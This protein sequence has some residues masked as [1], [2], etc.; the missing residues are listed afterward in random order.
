MKG[1]GLQFLILTWVG[2]FA[3]QN[4]SAQTVLLWGM[5]GSDAA[6]S[7]GVIFSIRGD[8]TSYSARFTFNGSS[9]SGPNLHLTQAH[10]AKLYGMTHAGGANNGGVIFRFDTIGNTCADLF[11]FGYPLTADP[12]G[13]LVLS[14]NGLLYG[15]VESG[16]PYHG[17]SIYSL[18]PATNTYKN[19]FYLDSTHGYSPFGSLTE[20][21]NNKLYGTTRYGGAHDAGVIFSFDPST[22]IYAK[23]YDFNSG[24][25]A[26][27]DLYLASNGKLYGGAVGG[28]FGKGVLFSFDPISNTYAK[29]FDFSGA[30][31]DGPGTL[32]Q[33]A[34]GNMYG[35]TGQGGAN[36]E[37]TIFSFNPVTALVTKLYDFGNSFSIYPRAL[38]LASDGLIYGTTGAGGPS[39]Y[40]RIFRFD[41]TNNSVTAI[42][43]FVAAT[44]YY[45]SGSLIEINPFITG[46]QEQENSNFALFPNPNNGMCS[47]VSKNI[48]ANSE[49][50][51]YTMYGQRIFKERIISE[52]TDIDLSKESKGLFFYKVMYEGKC[53]HSGK[54]I[55]Y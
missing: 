31:G 13:A 15:L 26:T 11:D 27:S 54:I 33:L 37:G 18:D 7:N 23:L 24:S 41:P 43:D 25:T 34:N 49:L 19:L 8:G 4:M 1:R 50:E 39:S 35:T 52:R 2:M 40:G 20:A 36:N 42:H 28:S 53:I 9:G 30:N 48:Q 22:G 51:L 14:K 29:L 45:S 3:F 44:G 21:L 16:G 55:V 12:Q 32:I 6:G 10:G 47:L 17:G 5:T 38:M 46:I